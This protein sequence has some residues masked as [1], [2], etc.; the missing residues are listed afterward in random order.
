[1]KKIVIT[2]LMM[3]LAFTMVASAESHTLVAYYSL[4]P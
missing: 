2:L 4:N 1:M 3:M